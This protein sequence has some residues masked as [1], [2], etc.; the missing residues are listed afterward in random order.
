MGRARTGKPRGRAPAFSG[1]KLDFL[2]SFKDVFLGRADAGSLYDDIER[3]WFEKYGFDLPLIQNPPVDAPP[4][5]LDLS[6][7]PIEDQLQIQQS[8]KTIRKDFRIVSN[9]SDWLTVTVSDIRVHRNW[10]TSFATGLNIKHQIR[11]P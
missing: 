3:Q 7:L 1:E 10:A 5:N 2:D 4:V 8:R 6:G 11:T 9:C